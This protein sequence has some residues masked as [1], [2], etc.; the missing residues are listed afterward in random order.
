MRQLADIPHSAGTS[1]VVTRAS[2][3][4]VFET[5]LDT[6]NIPVPFEQRTENRELREVT[7][8]LSVKYFF[9]TL[10]LSLF[11]PSLASADFRINLPKRTKPTKV[12][13]LNRD[14]VKAVQKH[15]YDEARKF[16]YKAYLLDPDDPFTLNNLGYMAELDGD[17]DRAARFYDLAQQQNS[18]AMIDRADSEKVVGKTVAQVAGHAEQGN[19]QVNQLNIRAL[20]L[21]KQDRAAEA[22]MVLTKSLTLEPKNPFTLNNLGFAKEKEGELEAALGYYSKAALTGSQE[23]IIVTLHKD[24]RGHP[25]SEVAADN[26]QKVRMLIRQEQGA[27]RLAKVA[28][29]NLQ[30]VSALNRNDKR[31]ARGYFEE[32]YKL[33][34]TDAFTLNNMGYVAEMEG[35]RESAQFFYAKAQQ[36]DHSSQLV[37]AS[38]R[39]EAEGHKVS[40]VA[41]NSQTQVEGKME[42]AIQQ[43]RARGVAPTLKRRGA[44]ASEP[45]P[46]QDQNQWQ[47][48]PQPQPDQDQPQ[49][50]QAPP[51]QN[52]PKQSPPQ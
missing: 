16:F 46:T 39:A 52:Q 44:T 3:P 5:C 45:Q 36:A 9:C 8:V 10:L 42:A 48:Q 47:Q 12:Q 43:R 49:P 14:G 50:Q 35:D 38:N 20:Q 23:P 22:D 18:D 32:A 25:I 19:M 1:S 13:Q 40:S 26:A 7:T 34:P 37:T 21:L 4:H 30:G 24:W 33:D 15:D 28:R 31:A 11:L 29:L 27:D 6:V 41:D 2:C 17:L 51:D